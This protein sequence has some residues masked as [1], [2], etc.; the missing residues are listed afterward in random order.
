MWWD[1]E[2]TSKDYR[3][4]SINKINISWS[5][6]YISG[7]EEDCKGNLKFYVPGIDLH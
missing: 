5:F 4:F 3:F 1:H 7:Y 6:R 2:S